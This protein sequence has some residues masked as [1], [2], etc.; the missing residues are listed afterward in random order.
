MKS[1]KQ[2]IVVAIA[3]IAS[4]LIIEYNDSAPK[5]TKNKNK[6]IDDIVSVKSNN[7]ST[8]NEGKLIHLV[9]KIN[10]LDILRDHQ[11]GIEINTIKLRR[12]VYMYQWS[13]K[14]T[15]RQIKGNDGSVK[16]NKNYNYKKR[17]ARNI[18]DSD[19]FEMN[20]DYNNPKIMPVSDLTVSAKN[21]T[22]GEY[23]VPPRIINSLNNFS[24]YTA[25][26]LNKLAKI[27]GR[28]AILINGEIFLGLDYQKPEVGDVKIVFRI[29]KPVIVSLISEQSGTSFKP[30]ETSKGKTI[31]LIKIGTHS[32]SEI[33]KSN[34]T[35]RGGK[36]FPRILVIVF[37]VLLI[38]FIKRKT[39]IIKAVPVEELSEG[40][41]NYE[42]SNEDI[43]TSI[44]SS[45][46]TREMAEVTDYK[47]EDD[48]YMQEFESEDSFSQ[49]SISYHDFSRREMEIPKSWF[50]YGHGKKYG[51]H[52]LNEIK[53]FLAIK[54]VTLETKCRAE[55]ADFKI[56]IIMIPGIDS[57]QWSD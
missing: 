37:F 53:I 50:L 46:N 35:E 21:I 5:K 1:K 29:V 25:D 7:I 10:T 57:D 14:E 20:S 55:D 4:L 28:N 43:S 34:T 17:W 54:K 11:F 27:N 16:V 45:S 30:Y 26:K 41:S 3:F 24:K 12:E 6:K 51:P 2:V 36:L 31:E 44:E 22:I 38:L 40:N 52:D 15:I 32:I 56:T 13:E 8:E 49:G 48:A 47:P 19:S 23:K 42:N 33:I 39:G 18:I 9:G